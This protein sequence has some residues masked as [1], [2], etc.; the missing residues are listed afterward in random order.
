MR[1]PLRTVL[2]K[3]TICLFDPMDNPKVVWNMSARQLAHPDEPYDVWDAIVKTELESRADLDSLEALQDERRKLIAVHGRLL[4]LWGREGQADH[5]RKRRVEA[6]KVKVR[7]ELSA[8]REKKPTESEIDAAAHGS[9]AYGAFLDL[10]LADH[11]ESLQVENRITEIRE[12]IADR[13]QILKAYTE[14]IVAHRM[15]PQ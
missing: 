2:R 6:E 4:A 9:E 3:T 14:E 13:S 15:T 10:Q 5:F 1:A 8:G 11:I 12:L 7:M